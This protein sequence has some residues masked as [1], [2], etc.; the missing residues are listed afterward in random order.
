VGKNKI[1]REKWALGNKKRRTL[2]SFKFEN[3]NGMRKE[4]VLY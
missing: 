1:E 4:F 3:G 2:K